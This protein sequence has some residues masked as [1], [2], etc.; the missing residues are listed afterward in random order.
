M[1]PITSRGPMPTDRGFFD[2]LGSDLSSIGSSIYDTGSS[3]L[4]KIT[5]LYEGNGDNSSFALQ[6]SQ[7]PALTTGDPSIFVMPQST[8]GAFN[9]SLGSPTGYGLTSMDI[10]NAMSTSPSD[11]MGITAAQVANARNAM[12]S[13]GI[14]VG[15]PMTF[16]EQLGSSWDKMN[17]FVND[18]FGGWGNVWTGI[19]AIGNMYSGVK[20]LGLM[21]DQLDLARDQFGFNKALTSKNLANQVKSYN[22]ALADKYR[23]RA[24]TETG[25]A[26]A[27][28]KQIEERK[29]DG[30][31]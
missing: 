9:Q 17:G 7:T 1:Y 26:N 30:K 2:Q 28:D 23:A 19:Q 16:G 14:G 3:I 31:I 29:L 21:Q 10:A 27:Y 6:A 13:Q 18:Q 11:G 22:T 15:N 20:Q 25:N 12:P 4:D 24:F 8:T 5:A